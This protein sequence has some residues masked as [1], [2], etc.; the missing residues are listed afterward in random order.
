MK[1]NAA[2][3]SSNPAAS[4]HRRRNDRIATADATNNDDE[5]DD[6][7]EEGDDDED[8]ADPYGGLNTRMGTMSIGDDT[9]ADNGVNAGRGFNANADA[10]AASIANSQVLY[11]TV[12]GTG[13]WGVS[14]VRDEAADGLDDDDVFSV[15]RQIENHDWKADVGRTGRWIAAVAFGR[16]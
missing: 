2:S 15:K 9:Y 12:K 11:E 8:G 13:L 14:R 7:H 6:Y 5:A 16:E 4:R 3:S 1:Q 10:I